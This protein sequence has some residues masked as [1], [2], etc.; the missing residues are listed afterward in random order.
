M[1]AS[2]EERS[3]FSSPRNQRR[4]MVAALAVLA[5][6]VGVFTF[7]FFRNTGD[8]TETF[9]NEPADIYKPQQTVGIDP[10]AKRIA[11][12]FIKT[13]VARQNLAASYDIVS[14]ELR[15]GMSRKQWASGNIPVVYYPSGDLQL[16]TFK[17]DRSLANEVVW[18]VFMVPKTGS[19]VQPAVFYIGLKR[20]GEKAPWKVFYWV[21]RYQPALPDPG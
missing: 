20:T 21:P 17:V 6:G 1:E 18:Q 4:I 7:V 2:S 16:A 10:D 9:S 19:G 15:Q 8:A 11:G 13:A 3:F 12:E 5:V 14:P